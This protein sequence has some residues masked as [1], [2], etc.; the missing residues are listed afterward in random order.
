MRGAVKCR[1]GNCRK[2]GASYDCVNRAEPQFL[3]RREGWFD[4][5]S[6]REL[7][8]R[9]MTPRLLLYAPVNIPNLVE[10]VGL[11]YTYGLP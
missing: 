4:G 11:I 9:A 10:G 6:G 1:D 5:A 7:A 3:C 8:P 2:S